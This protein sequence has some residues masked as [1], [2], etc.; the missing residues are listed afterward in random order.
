[1]PTLRAH[2]CSEA[3]A[4]MALDFSDSDKTPGWQ[5]LCV[6]VSVCVCVA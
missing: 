5:V 6:R 1:M 3:I 2:L 4:D